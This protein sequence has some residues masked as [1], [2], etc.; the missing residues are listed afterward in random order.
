MPYGADHDRFVALF[1]GRFPGQTLKRKQI[2]DIVQRANPHLKE[3]SI[4]PSDHDDRGNKRECG[5][6]KFNDNVFERIGY[7]KYKVH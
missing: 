2:V 1:K 7:G 4:L 5:C 6:R 3:T